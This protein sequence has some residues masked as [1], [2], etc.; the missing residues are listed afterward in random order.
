MEIRIA[1]HKLRAPNVA[2]RDLAGY[3]EI[4]FKIQVKTVTHQGR[5]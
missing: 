4:K 3:V 5:L 1:I 2:A